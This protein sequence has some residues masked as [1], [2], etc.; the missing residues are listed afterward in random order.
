VRE[1][2][3]LLDRDS[4]LAE[5]AAAIGGDQ[6]DLG[7]V[8]YVE[9]E[10]GIGKTRLLEAA[11]S[12]AERRGLRVLAAT[13]GELERDFSYGVVRQLFEAA[14]AEAGPARSELLDGPAA[15]ATVAVGVEPAD[16][17]VPSPDSPFPVVHA[18]YWLTANLAAREPLLL[19]LDDAHWADSPSLRYLGYLAARLEGVPASVLVAARPAEPLGRVDLL[20][21]VRDRPGTVLVRPGP[22]SEAATS[23]AI[24]EWL[25][26]EPDPEF[27]SAC[28]EAS[29]GNPFLLTE[30]VGAL[31]A[32]GIEPR[33]DAAAKVEALGPDTVARALMLRLSR[34]PSEAAAVADAV[35]VLGVAGEIR[36]VVAMTELAPEVVGEAADLL[37]DAHI[38]SR[39]R[40]LTFIHPVVRQ[41]IYRELR[42][43][44]RA[45]L[46]AGAAKAML[47]ERQQ[48]A[49][50]APHLLATQPA[51]D[52]AVVDVLRAAAASAFEQGA[53]DLAHT[54]LTRALA[55][56]P[57]EGSLA[58]VLAGLG[59]AEALG[60]RALEE[61]CRH[62]EEAAEHT[63][64]PAQRVGR[65][66]VAAQARVYRGDMRGAVELL[67]RELH[68]GS[69]D[70]DTALRLLAHQAA[71]GILQP[72]LAADSV[73]RLDELT[74]LSG[75]TPAELAVL[76]EIAA[77]RWL[78]GWIAEGA[79]YAE[80]ALEGGRLLAAEGPLSVSFHHAVAVLIDGDRY[81]KSLPALEAGIALAREHG[82]VLAYASLQGARTVASWRRG[83]LADVEADARSVLSL[84]EESPTPIVDSVHWGYLALALTERGELEEAD[85]AVARSAVG[86]D[87]PLLTSL[88]T[89][90]LARARLRLAQGRPED[91]LNDLLELDARDERLGV[92][93]LRVPWHWEAVEAC[94][95]LGDVD[96]AV[97]FA[98]KLLELARR[99][100]TPAARGLALS[101]KGLASQGEERIDL[102]AEGA[103]LLGQSPARLDSARAHVD[104]G[105]A[106]RRDGRP[107]Q[108][109][110]PLRLGLDTARACGAT[111]LMRR[112]NEELVTAGAR[113]RRLQFSGVESLTASERRVA[114]LAA[115]GDSNREIAAALFITVRTV[116]NHLSRAYRKLDIGSRRELSE[117]L[118][119][120]AQAGGTEASP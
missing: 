8:A 25:G 79:E 60:G 111:A 42:P 78:D 97:R 120:P 92:K 46:H 29:G 21:R 76:A 52:E 68:S 33:A 6:Q 119:A 71:I 15:L 55:E 45:R 70:A 116:E 62:L 23:S 53:A 66:E 59:L 40:P 49:S 98:D 36:H 110:E 113:P 99:W 37:S 19:V 26:S 83:M 9:G 31:G 64:E 38:L 104:L 48:P 114:K 57:P 50:V 107:A 35:A 73:R 105:A 91:A 115:G 93:H 101:A 67:D 74:E 7:G 11:R 22:L 4:E 30:L 24:R 47:V 82:S 28:H 1:E 103:A 102:L 80:R 43:S 41:A 81:E 85:E 58:D 87:L 112:A 100:D 32:D 88:G 109:R 108:A 106:L 63:A 20:A 10:P 96:R 17:R 118:G 13:G 117:A 69:V 5:I 12:R 54:Y 95:A 3:T 16:A 90:F 89:P 65:V 51:N 27:A 39:S 2:R 94:L 77:S 34:L 75:E 72:P 56:P 18:L 14:V 86:P 84:V 61:A 44:A